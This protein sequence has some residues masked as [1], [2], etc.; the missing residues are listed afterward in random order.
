MIIDSLSKSN[1][2]STIYIVSYHIS[3]TE[4]GLINSKC[5]HL[6]VTIGII[7]VLT[8]YIS[9]HFREKTHWYIVILIGLI[10]KYWF[11]LSF[12]STSRCNINAIIAYNWKK[13]LTTCS[14]RFPVFWF[15]SNIVILLKLDVIKQ[16]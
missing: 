8:C 2:A 12:Y 13:I 9:I 6:L 15:K 4:N 1:I 16:F 10:I 11:Y 3:L 14:N 5:S 7:R